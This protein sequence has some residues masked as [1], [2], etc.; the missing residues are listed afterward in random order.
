MQPLQLD[1]LP[2]IER[3]VDFVGLSST[4]DRWRSSI[5]PTDITEY[6]MEYYHT[7]GIKSWYDVYAYFLRRRI[8]AFESADSPPS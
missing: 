7:P 1:Q 8:A 5:E 6:L 4:I 3:R 2:R